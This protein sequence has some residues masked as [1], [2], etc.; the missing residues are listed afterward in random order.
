MVVDIFLTYYW[1]WRMYILLVTNSTKIILI[2]Q[3]LRLKCW[4]ILQICIKLKILKK[5]KGTLVPIAHPRHRPVS[6]ACGP[7]CQRRLV[8]KS[9]EF[10]CCV[11]YRPL[12][13]S[14]LTL[15]CQSHL[16]FRPMH[17]WTLVSKQPAQVSVQPL[18]LC[19]T[20]DVSLTAAG[21]CNANQ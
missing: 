5:Q 13:L 9:S 4:K 10:D 14:P 3:R 6:R 11:E 7:R 8:F 16:L 1:M 2:W 21:Y 19:T 20:T 12:Q 15:T 17:T 18:N